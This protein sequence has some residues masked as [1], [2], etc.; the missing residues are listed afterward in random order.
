MIALNVIVSLCVFMSNQ[1]YEKP[2]VLVG[3]TGGDEIHIWLSYDFQAYI[4]IDI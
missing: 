4:Y 3:E 1:P 2:F